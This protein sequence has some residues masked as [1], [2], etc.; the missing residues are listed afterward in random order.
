MFGS[1][2][3]ILSDNIGEFNYEEFNQLCKKF[4]ITVKATAA[5]SP[6]SNG[7]VDRHNDILGDMID[8]LILMA[9]S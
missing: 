3:T 9:T 5:E 8:K 1:P 4:N 6:W 7:V 2:L